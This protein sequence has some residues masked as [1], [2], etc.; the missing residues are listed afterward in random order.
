[1][2]NLLH[3]NKLFIILLILSLKLHAHQGGHFSQGS[4]KSLAFKN[5]QTV[6][7]NFLYST[8]KEIILEQNGGNLVRIPTVV[9]AKNDLKLALFKIKKYTQI[10]QNYTQRNSINNQI[11]F[12]KCLIWCI[13]YF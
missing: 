9:L 5:G 13:G 7:G 6:S 2:R 11:P 8:T 10:H 12:L 1:M 4:F 3:L